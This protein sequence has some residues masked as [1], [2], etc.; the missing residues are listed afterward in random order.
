MTLLKGHWPEEWLTDAVPTTSLSPYSCRAP[1][2]IDRHPDIR[3]QTNASMQDATPSLTTDGLL[4]LQSHTPGSNKL[5][6]H[7]REVTP[8]VG[9][10]YLGQ[11]AS[12]IVR[13]DESRLGALWN[14]LVEHQ[15]AD[16]PQ[17]TIKNPSLS[18]RYKIS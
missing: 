11:G 16:I 3:Q 4:N 1:Q 12:K 14:S 8:E 5:G 7:L 15:M 9:L 2:P 17:P 18:S 10:F 6:S 13:F